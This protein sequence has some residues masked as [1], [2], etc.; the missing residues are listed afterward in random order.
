MYDSIKLEGSEREASDE[1][2][3]RRLNEEIGRINSVV[4][5]EQKSREESEQT[6]F[7]MLKDIINKIKS[8]IE[9][10]RKERYRALWHYLAYTVVLGRRARIRS[11]GYL[12]KHA[13]RSMLRALE[14]FIIA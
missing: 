2:I 11:F 12:K 10:E 6:I 5:S 1:N 13:R 3:L 14:C 4:G 7:E 8:E 9:S